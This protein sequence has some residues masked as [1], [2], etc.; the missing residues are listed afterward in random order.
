[1]PYRPPAG[2]KHTERS[3]PADGTCRSAWRGSQIHRALASA[4]GRFTAHRSVVLVSYHSYS[5]GRG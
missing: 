5:V 3:P 1:V 2:L 4:G